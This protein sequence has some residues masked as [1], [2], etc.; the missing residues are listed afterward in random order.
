[1]ETEI[2]LSRCSGDTIMIGLEDS[3]SVL[4]T[5]GPLKI[6]RHQGILSGRLI[7]HA[8]DVWDTCVLIVVPE[9]VDPR[10]HQNPRRDRK[11]QT[12]TIARLRIEESPPRIGG[13]RRG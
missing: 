1:M 11:L 9:I 3:R 5:Y 2:D 10:I 4:E 7:L 8:G 6:R 13:I 12:S